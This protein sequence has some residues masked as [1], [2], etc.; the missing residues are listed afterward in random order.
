MKFYFG[1]LLHPW[2]EKLSTDPEPNEADDEDDQESLW[3]ASELFADLVQV[4]WQDAD[5]AEVASAEVTL[6]RAI[7]SDVVWDWFDDDDAEPGCCNKKYTLQQK[8]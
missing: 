1:I 3:I 4:L 7:L 6:T 5:S 2:S 8:Y